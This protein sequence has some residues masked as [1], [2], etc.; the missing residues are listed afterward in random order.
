MFKQPWMSSV[1][2]SVRSLINSPF[3]SV[4][5]FLT[6]FNTSTCFQIPRVVNLSVALRSLA[7]LAA[8]PAVQVT[9]MLYTKGRL[10]YKRGQS[11]HFAY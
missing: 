11:S 5:A 10:I 2:S 7:G 9:V 3:I 6:V 4:M 1:R 8:T